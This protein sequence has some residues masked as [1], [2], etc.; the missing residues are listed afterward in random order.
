MH[1]ART[2]NTPRRVIKKDIRLDIRYDLTI[3]TCA[4]ALTSRIIASLGY[5]TFE[6]EN[7]KEIYLELPIL[8]LLTDGAVTVI[9]FDFINYLKFLLIVPNCLRSSLQKN[10]N[11]RLH[12]IIVETHRWK[13]EPSATRDT[14]CIYDSNFDD[15][16]R[17]SF[18]FH[19]YFHF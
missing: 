15:I 1:D 6:L 3:L 11:R 10:C 4:G 16:R 19:L 13:F 8:K 5:R 2:S 12:A 7:K 17:F 14:V 18:V 9:V